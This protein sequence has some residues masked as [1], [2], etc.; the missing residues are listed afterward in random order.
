VAV[1][2]SQMEVE[3]VEVCRREGVGGE[4]LWMVVAEAE[5]PRR[6]G[7]VVDHDVSEK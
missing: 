5:A 6:A 1:V 2:D 4:V 7:E 3:G